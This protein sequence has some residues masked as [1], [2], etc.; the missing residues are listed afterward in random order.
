VAVRVQSTAGFTLTEVAV[1]SGRCLQWATL[2]MEEVQMVGLLRCGTVW[3]GGPFSSA[4]WYSAWRRCR[5][6]LAQVLCGT[7][8]WRLVVRSVAQAHTAA[9]QGRELQHRR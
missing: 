8:R 7:V 9:V 4:M 1:Q 3:L 6:G 2:D 5:C